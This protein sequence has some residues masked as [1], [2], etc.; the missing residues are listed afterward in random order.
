MGMDKAI[1][2]EIKKKRKRKEIIKY[3]IAGCVAL[4]GII[5]VI[6]TFSS[7]VSQKEIDVFTVDSGVIET[8][9]SAS[10]KVVPLSQEV[11]TSPVSSKILEVYKRSGDSLQ[12]GD[13]IL[14]LDLTEA[15]TSMENQHDELEMKRYKLEQQ[16]LNAESSLSEMKMSIEVDEMKLQRMEVQLQNEYYMDSL[17]AST[18]DKVKEAELEYMVQKKNLEQLKLKYENLKRTTAADLRIAELDYTIATKNASLSNKTLSE[19]QVRSPQ[20]ATLTWVNDAIGSSV[21]AGSEL[22]IVANLKE[23]KVEAT[24]SDS[25]ADKV[26]PGNKAIV[27]IGKENL[28][29]QVGNVTPSVSNGQITFVVTLDDNNHPRLRS[30]LNVEVYVVHGMRD[31][32]VRLQRRAF[33][34]GNGTYDLWVIEGNEATKRQV[35]LGEGSF[36][37]V[38][39]LEGLEPG[40][41]VI[42]S[43]MNRFRD[44]NTLKIK[45]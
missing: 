30:G 24:I 29:G 19:A 18:S 1:S 8:T 35:K 23:F 31:D 42:V 44:N 21:A 38:E 12:V 41:K 39:V 22:A 34:S 28:T 9:V 16:K 14:K 27:K 25:Y 2:P 4:I 3:S 10:G 13:T 40:D 43:D 20:K 32:A 6:R 36:E 26:L 45:D 15:R 7:G 5:F 17:G 37:Y 11:I 33:Y